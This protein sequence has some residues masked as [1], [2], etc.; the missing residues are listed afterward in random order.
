[1]EKIRMSGKWKEI[2][3]LTFKG[4]RFEDNSIEIPF[5]TELI[6]YQKMIEHSS[7]IIWRILEPERKRMP[8]GFEKL[9]TLRFNEIKPNCVTIPLK[10]R[11]T[12][13]TQTVFTALQKSVHL[14]TDTIRSLNENISLPDQLPKSIVPEI[15]KWGSSLTGDDKIILKIPGG[16]EAYYTYSEREK[17]KKF[18]EGKYTDSIDITGEVLEVDI[19]RHNL[20]IYPD[21][22]SR[23]KVQFSPEQED[24]VIKALKEHENLMLKVKGTAVFKGTLHILEQITE[25]DDLYIIQK[26]EC[27]WDPNAKPFWEEILELAASI[28][29]EELDKLPTDLA[30]NID[31]YAYGSPKK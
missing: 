6:R 5:L 19:K 27:M 16:N 10:A 18:I 29:E 20:H 22:G 28:P 8:R 26:E 2:I 7:R 25:V 3:V 21:D 30:E 1:M 12:E 23:I 4:K 31:Y 13:L 11:G 15:A 17:M 14:V 24:I 9:V